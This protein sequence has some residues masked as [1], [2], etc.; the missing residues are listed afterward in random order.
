MGDEDSPLVIVRVGGSGW[1]VWVLW[2]PS[3]TR[4]P[5]GRMVELCFGI[6]ETGDEV[7]S[8]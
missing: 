5:C 7:N 6:Y 3:Q 1:L 4:E 8:I 2:N